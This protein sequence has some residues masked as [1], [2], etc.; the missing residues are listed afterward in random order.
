MKVRRLVYPL[1]VLGPG[2]RVGL[3]L[4]GC[5]RRCEGCCSPDLRE[6]HPVDEVP[7]SVLHD[8]LLPIAHKNNGML[9]MTIS[10]G[11]PLEQVAELS[12]LMKMLHQSGVKTEIL[13]YT[14][15]CLRELEN[16]P[17]TMLET[18]DPDGE[19]PYQLREIKKSRKF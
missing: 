18:T 1:Y 2:K 7:V 10:G 16:D 15:F 11:E 9:R 12:R 5:H 14:G 4:T 6:T 17:V 19:T 3:W 13:V 8:L